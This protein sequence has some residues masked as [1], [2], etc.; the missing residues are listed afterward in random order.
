MWR[1]DRPRV[2]RGDAFIG[3]E[4][5]RSIVDRAAHARWY[6]ADSGHVGAISID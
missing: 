4:W 2:E 1:C 3:A 6:V 5:S